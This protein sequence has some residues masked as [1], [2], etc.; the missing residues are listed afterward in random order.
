MCIMTD[1]FEFEAPFGIIGKFAERF[2]LER[3]MRKILTER[4]NVIKKI[5]QS[6]EWK[7]YLKDSHILCQKV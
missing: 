4:N 5:A 6:D 7:K 3:H 2:F 1:V